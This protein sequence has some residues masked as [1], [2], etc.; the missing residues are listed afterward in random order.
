LEESKEVTGDQWLVTI[1]RLLV[2]IPGGREIKVLNHWLSSLRILADGN[3]TPQKRK[4]ILA[5]RGKTSFWTRRSAFAAALA[6]LFALPLLLPAPLQAGKKKTDTAPPASPADGRV[7]AYFDISKIVWPSPPAIPRVAFKDIYTGEKIDPSLFAKKGRKKTWMDRLAGTLPVDQ[8]RLV[9]L[10]FQLTRPLGVAVDSKGNIYA[11]DQGVGA[12]FIFDPQNKDHVLLIGNGRQ[13]NF[14]LIA[15]LAI[16]DDDRLFVSDAKLHHVLAFNAGHEQE[17][18]FGA[19]VLVRPGGVAIDRE[20]RLLYVADTGNDVVDVFD[21]D[22]YKLLR[23]IGKPS[24][25]HDQTEPGTFSL[26]EGVAVDNE[27]NVF[28]TDTFNDRVEM[29]DAEGQFISAFGKNGDGP[30]DFERPKGIAIDRDGHIW[31]VDA[32]QNMVKIFNQQGR[33]LL[34]FGGP[35]YYPGQFMGPWGIAIG[36]SSQVV[37]SETF[38]GRVQVFRYITDAEAAT[39][40][41]QR[42]GEEQKPAVGSKPLAVAPNS[43]PQDAATKAARPAIEKT[44]AAQGTSAG[45]DVASKKDPA[46]H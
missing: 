38:P 11:A 21:V 43:D 37:V 1:I 33:L 23:Q 20:N 31:V 42:D 22:K 36:P 35:G 6:G 41:A 25:K 17:A 8:Q 10:P 19:Q 30:A 18:S 16:D 40:K 5:A 14:G 15:G 29:F 34:Y 27:G 46:A 39:L 28:V 12:V 2:E 32:A 26:P 45:A 13:A 24:K 4:E 3:E 9:N 7:T 44:P